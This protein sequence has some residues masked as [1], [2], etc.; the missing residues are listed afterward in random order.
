[1][2]QK[3]PLD[4]LLML[5]SSV[6]LL[7]AWQQLVWSGTLTPSQL[8]VYSVWVG[9]LIACGY[10]Y[11][12]GSPYRQ[13]HQ[14][15]GWLSQTGLPTLAGILGTA[16]LALDL[17]TLPANAQATGG[18][19]TGSS[20]GFFFTN[21]QTKVTNVFAGSAQASTVNPLVLFTFGILQILFIML[22]AWQIAKVV[23]A[24]R[25]EED[26]KQVAKTPIIVVLAIVG[27]DWA[28]GL[29]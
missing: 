13:L 27:G 23:G 29:I 24:A 20:A 2:T 15:Q 21:L 22:V 8:L 19:A 9:L 26:W 10:L 6:M 25:D 11:W 14:L 28:I 4:V 16:I 7:Y 1:M 18:G 3:I 17:F 12:T 5:N